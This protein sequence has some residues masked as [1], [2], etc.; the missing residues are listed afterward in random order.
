MHVNALSTQIH[1]N[2]NH[3]LSGSGAT[4]SFATFTPTA[5]LPRAIQASNGG[6]FNPPMSLRAAPDSKG[7][8][9]WLNSIFQ[10]SL[11]AEVPNLDLALKKP[12]TQTNTQKNDT[13]A[14]IP[15][16]ANTN[17]K[18]NKKNTNVPQTPK[19]NPIPPSAPDPKEPISRKHLLA[20]GAAMTTVATALSNQPTLSADISAINDLVNW[21]DALISVGAGAGAAGWVNL[22]SSL[23]EQG[24]IDS[25]TTRKLIHITS[26]PMFMASWPLFSESPAARFVAAAVPLLQ[27]GRLVLASQDDNSKMAS[28]ISRSNKGSE[29][30]KGPAIYAGILALASLA[31]R[32]NPGAITAI[33]QMAVGDGMADI[34]GRNFAP[35]DGS[36]RIPWNKDKSIAGTVGYIASASAATWGM[37]NW[38]A[39]QG[40]LQPD[41]PVL[42]AAVGL[43]VLCGL[44]ETLPA[45]KIGID[46]NISVPLAAALL[47]QVLFGQHS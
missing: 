16:P 3:G 17:N 19:Q 32:D 46:D 30:L 24:I 36:A 9:H 6:Q 2:L 35:K 44:I 33:T 37:I 8:T 7:N 23:A 41:T 20:A 5:R 34:V 4:N 12:K 39:A 14:K 15:K 28:A 26:A 47:G 45:E 25:K 40:L 18:K 11:P 22:W 38:F 27:L 10:E 1:T 42:P 21:K 29:L 13:P 43:S 31:W